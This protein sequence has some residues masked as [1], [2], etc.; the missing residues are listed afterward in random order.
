MNIDRSGLRF[1]EKLKLLRLAAEFTQQNIADAL[2]VNRATYAYYELGK[3]MPDIPTVGKLAKIFGV[4]VEIF[5][6]EEMPTGIEVMRDSKGRER[7]RPGK[8]VGDNPHR[9]GDLSPQEKA[10]ISL[11]RSTDKITAEETTLALRQKL[12]MPLLEN[13]EK[14]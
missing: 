5:F 12:G 3:T 8:I 6:H 1:G 4:P 10:L 9:I 14:E 2:A 11:L 13:Q 7:K